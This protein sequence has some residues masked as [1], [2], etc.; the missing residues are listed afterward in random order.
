MKSLCSA[1]LVVSFLFPA[2]GHAQAQ[3]DALVASWYRQ[4][5]G[6]NPDPS[7]QGW[8]DIL[9][10]GQAPDLVLAQILG[11]TEY[12]D[13]AG[14]TPEGFVQSLYR[15]L[16]GRGPSR[17]QLVEGVRVVEANGLQEAAHRVLSMQAR[18]FDERRSPTPEALVRK[19]Y[20]RFLN[21]EPEQAGLVGWTSEL[22]RGASRES[23][24]AR[25]IGS[26]E[27]WQKSGS[28]AEGFVRGVYWD[29]LQREPNRRDVAYWA[30]KAS[31]EGLEATALAMLQQLN[32]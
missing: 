10:V 30:H 28:T 3:P 5:L 2:V 22:N 13:R 4:Y 16:L 15:D 25:I 12:Y 20:N 21:R 17:Q 23:V 18:R 6:R 14:S 24:M 26:D 9:R 7:A 29:I 32:R 31:A 8:V 27:Y 1:A 11:S 19:W